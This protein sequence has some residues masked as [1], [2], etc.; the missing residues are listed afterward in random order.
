MAATINFNTQHLADVYLT[1]AEGNAKDALI[2]FRTGAEGE[3]SDADKAALAALDNRIATFQNAIT[4][5]PSSTAASEDFPYDKDLLKREF[6]EEVFAMLLKQTKPKNT[7]EDSK[8]FW[9]VTANTTEDNNSETQYTPT[10]IGLQKGSQFTDGN[11]FYGGVQLIANSTMTSLEPDGTGKKSGVKWNPNVLSDS[12]YA[13]L[14]A[15]LT[16]DGQKVWDAY[17]NWIDAVFAEGNKMKNNPVDLNTGNGIQSGTSTVITARTI[18]GITYDRVSYDSGKYYL[19]A[20]G[21]QTY[22]GQK[23]T[24]AG[25]VADASTGTSSAGPAAKSLIGL[26]PGTIKAETYLEVDEN[27]NPINGIA[28]TQNIRRNLSPMWYLY[29]WNEARINVLR[30]QLNFKEAIT[31]ELRDDLAKANAAYADLQK[32]MGLTHAQST[33][34]STQLP[35]ASFE[36]TTM[37]FFEATNS[38]KGTPIFDSTNDDDIHNYNEW[39][40]NNSTLKTYIDLKNTQ[41]QNAMLDYQTTLNRYNNAYD[42][43]SKLQ[44]KLQGLV[45]N[46]LRNIG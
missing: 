18:N 3:T 45:T 27:L 25:V 32:V 5:T 23:V 34:G 37:D 13:T 17:M 1:G 19:V 35:D 22:Q 26:V 9:Y 28:V 6:M 43:M 29:Y 24:S 39:G 33:N 30:G 15:T 14:R 11:A 44:E 40:K 42:V 21:A 16:S 31:S 46:Q 4:D 2:A 10:Y 12:S 38:K 8:W 7:K 20:Q 36:T 41:S